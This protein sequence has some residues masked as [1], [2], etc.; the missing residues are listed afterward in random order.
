[1]GV[2]RFH[3]MPFTR[4]PCNKPEENGRNCQKIGRPAVLSSAFSPPALS[5]LGPLT[6]RC[7]QHKSSSPPVVSPLHIYFRRCFML[8]NVFCCYSGFQAHFLL[9]G[10]FKSSS[11]VPASLKTFHSHMIIFSFA[12]VCIL[13]N[14][15]LLQ[16]LFSSSGA[17]RFQIQA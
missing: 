13:Y 7:F 5:P 9:L 12:S 16:S 11:S 8:K 2:S 6:T 14:C 10:F 15:Q 4:H 17:R 1:M 3:F